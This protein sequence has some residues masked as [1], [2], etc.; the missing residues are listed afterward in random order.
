MR[1]PPKPP[2]SKQRALRGTHPPGRPKKG[3]AVITPQDLLV[4]GRDYLR[5]VSQIE[6]AQRYG[7][8]PKT[9]CE[10]IQRHVRPVWQQHVG[11]DLDADLARVAE[12]EREAW[13]RYSNGG[14]KEDLADVWHAIEHRAKIFGFYAAKKHDVRGG[15]DAPR[16]AGLTPAEYAEWALNRIVDKAK[17]LRARDEAM[18]RKQGLN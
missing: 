12:I 2:T 15:A 4:I 5:G 13:E 17:E 1:N 3:Q 16:V 11:A 9:I 6:L 10:H 8:N 18:Q 14:T 7:V